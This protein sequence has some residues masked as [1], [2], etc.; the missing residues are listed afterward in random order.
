MIEMAIVGHHLLWCPCVFV[1]IMV[2]VI[3]MVMK[4]QENDAMDNE[5]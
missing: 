2:V 1:K 3:M 4:N 5:R